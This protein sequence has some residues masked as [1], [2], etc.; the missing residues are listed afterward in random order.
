MKKFFPLLLAFF[1]VFL[2]S[3]SQ[4]NNSN[5]NAKSKPKPLTFEQQTKQ[6]LIAYMKENLKDPKSATLDNFEIFVSNDSICIYNFDCTAKN[7]F[8]AL[9]KSK[10]SYSNVKVNGKIYQLFSEESKGLALDTLLAKDYVEIYLETKA[11]TKDAYNK[12]KKMNRKDFLSSME[13]EMAKNNSDKT[14]VTKTKKKKD[15]VK[16]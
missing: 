7:G 10:Y 9:D 4:G 16:L 2:A 12:Y 3:C 1:I 5:N 6:N 15:A 11:I 14:E 13:Y 8:G